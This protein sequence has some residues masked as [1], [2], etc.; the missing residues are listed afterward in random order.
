VTA[1]SSLINDGKNA[2][3][4]PQTAHVTAGKTTRITLICDIM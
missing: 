1:A 3:S 2:C 4:R